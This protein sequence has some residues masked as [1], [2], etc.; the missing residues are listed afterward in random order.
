MPFFNPFN[1]VILIRRERVG[2][3][4][5]R[6]LDHG[7]RLTQAVGH[8]CRICGESR[9]NESFSGRGHK[10]HVCKR[11]ARLPKEQRDAA[12]QTD[13][14]YSFLHQSH[15]SAKNLAC[16]REWARSKN[17]EVAELARIV[18][19]VAEVKPH[20]KRRLRVLAIE[21]P[22]LLRKLEETGLIFAHHA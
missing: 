11:C 19:E 18:I 5:Q 13:A 16:L 3:R 9:P 20:K 1:P 6:R 15:I 7:E 8:Y 14:I 21:R 2:Q 12:E 22:D 17:R 10:T 4:K